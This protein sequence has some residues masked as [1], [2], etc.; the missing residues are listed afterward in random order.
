[1]KCDF[2]HELLSGYLDGELDGKNKALVEDHLKSCS[3]CQQ[4]LEALKKQ[5]SLVRSRE[6][7][8]PSREFVFSLNRRVM[9]QVMKKPRFSFWRYMPVLVPTAVAAL[10]LVVVF[11][12]Q[13]ETRYVTTDDQIL[14]PVVSRLGYSDES[15]LK[16]GSDRSVAADKKVA[17][18]KK[19]KA[20][21]PAG[22][23]STPPPSAP[24]QSG[25]ELA[26]EIEDVE[27]G[28]LVASE[29]RKDV[30]AGKADEV[31]TMTAGTGGQGAPAAV[32]QLEVPKNQVVRAIVDSTGKIIKVVTG[33]TIVPEEDTIL[34]K[35][36]EGQQ[37]AP[38]TVRGRRTQMYVDLSEP[39]TDTESDSLGRN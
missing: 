19:E 17:A 28:P 13:H 33:N 4:F 26:R 5:D 14:L 7:E 1:M 20:A 16:A 31:E 11:N 23:A 38:P 32:A 39:K 27:L 37:M 29:S 3:S 15:G 24:S 30:D 35:Q 2:P 36:L 25:G 8:E 6:I 10:V 21:E 34:E 18:A 9:D 12:S 22:V